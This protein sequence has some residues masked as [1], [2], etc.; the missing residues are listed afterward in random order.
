VRDGFLAAAL[1]EPAGQRPRVEILDTASLGAAAA[2]ARAL[3]VGAGAVAG[4]L[5]K[6]DV[7][8]L[9]A[10]RALPVPTLALNTV[11]LESPPPFLFQFALDPEQEA[12]AV[13]RRIV[14]DG[15]VRGIA[16]FPRSAWGER[17]QAAFTEELAGTDV[18]LT[19]AQFYDPATK[20]YS[21]PLRAAL[22]RFGG[23]GDR[24]PTGTPPKRD[25]LAEARDGPQFVFV[26]ASAANARTLVPQLHFQMT[27]EPALY[28][29]SDA[30]DP[31]PRTV[32]DLEGLIFPEMPW[33]LD[34]G[35]E[36]PALWDLLQRG[37]AAEA[38]GRMRLYAFGYDAYR[39]LRGM[40]A[41]TRGIATGGLTGRLLV[42]PDGR[43][44]R[45]PD[46]AQ[47]RGGR[48]QDAGVSQMP[49]VPGGP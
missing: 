29:T 26:A 32:P 47:I 44:Q 23:A 33:I 30:V 48:P 42:T 43:V 5:V 15:H 41:A 40:S 13:A 10:S 38:R 3:E 21:G 7:A 12:R 19:S 2:Y 24:G 8:A 39:L 17:V 18:E 20:D 46:W 37:W 27:Y 1:G 28:S 45:E 31:G 36:A 4:P 6:E 22:G 9:V 16:L 11:P 14:R 35:L 49:A 25:A 34:G